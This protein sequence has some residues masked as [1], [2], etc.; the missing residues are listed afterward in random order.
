METRLDNALYAMLALLIDDDEL[1]RL[2]D[3]AEYI[4]AKIEHERSP[5]LFPP[6]ELAELAI[7]N[8]KMAEKDNKPINVNLKELKEEQRSIVGIHEIYGQ[9]YEE[10]GFSSVL[11]GFR[12]KKPAELLR[13]I[14]MARIA[15]PSSKREAVI[16]LERD[17]G[18]SLNLDRVY[19]M[20][21]KIDDKAIQRLEDCAFQA[22]HQLLGGKVDVIFVDATTLYFESF[23]E[24]DLKKNGYSKDLKFNQPQVLFSL[25]VTKEGLPIGYET[26]PGSTYEG[27]TLLPLLEKIKSRFVIDQS[28]V[29]GRQRTT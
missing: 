12:N 2:K 3:L 13:H 25:I 8:R 27:H 7:R 1:E 26:F 18:I 9:I 29:C 19:R 5:L 21:D 23:T 22:T 6:E 24:D 10:L 11:K 28:G 20:M 17:F 15:N 16:N 4:R 14:V